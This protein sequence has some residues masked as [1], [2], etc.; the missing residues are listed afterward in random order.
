MEAARSARNYDGSKGTLWQW[1][2]GIAHHRVA[3]FY[4]QEA[5]QRRLKQIKTWCASWD[6]DA[7]DWVQG[8]IDLPQVVL[9]SSELADLVRLTMAELSEDYA[10][11]LPSRYLDGQSAVEIAHRSGATPEEIRA[12]LL[13]AR[14]RFRE[15]FLNHAGADAYAYPRGAS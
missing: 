11:L 5:Q 8:E 3:N 15:V 10:L 4:R 14:R 13:R 7:R 9:E 12:K 6:S 2:Y 1:L